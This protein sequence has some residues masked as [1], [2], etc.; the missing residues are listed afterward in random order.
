MK[1]LKISL[2]CLLMTLGFFGI[3]ENSN[4]Q[5]K[6]ELRKVQ[7]TQNYFL[8]DSVLNSRKFVFNVD[9]ITEMYDT[10]RNKNANSAINFI[11]VDGD[12]GVFQTGHNS[13]MGD[14]GVGGFTAEGKI[15]SWNLFQDSKNLNHTLT[16]AFFTLRGTFSITM[17][18]TSG[19]HAT[20]LIG[21]DMWIG[22][23]A[24]LDNSGIYKGRIQ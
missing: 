15:T 20:A 10:Y 16:F 18:V 11:E 4:S 22:H 5:S 14:N 3:S 13:G 1:T 24:S 8:M 21:G 23:L 7:S 9:F 6:K 19:N 12:K 2:V 17:Y